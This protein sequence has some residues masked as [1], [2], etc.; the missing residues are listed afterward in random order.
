MKFSA[1][2]FCIDMINIIK[3][4]RLC[5]KYGGWPLDNRSTSLQ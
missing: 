4:I 1:T 3:M 2:G 5:Y